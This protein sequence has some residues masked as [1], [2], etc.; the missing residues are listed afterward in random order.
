MKNKLHNIL[1]YLCIALSSTAAYGK[2]DSLSPYKHFFDFSGYINYKAFYD[3]RQV[4]GESD[5][6]TLFYPKAKICSPTG[7]I[8][9]KG[10][11]QMLPIETR[12]RVT[13]HGPNIH[14]NTREKGIIEV[15]FRGNTNGNNSVNLVN[16]RHAYGQLDWNKSTFIF[17]QTWHPLNVI[18]LIPNTVSFNSGRPFAVYT[19]SP[20]VNYTYHAPSLDIIVAATSQVD[21]DSDGPLGLSAQYMRDAVIPNLHFQLKGF[22]Q[23]HITTGIGI[24]YQRITP[25]LV[26][27]TGYKVKENLSSLSGIYYLKLQW[28]K[29]DIRNTL[30]FGGNVSNYGLIGGYA[31]EKRSINPITQS[32]KYTTTRTLSGWSDWTIIPT[33]FFETGW[34]IGAEKNYG[35]RK[36]IEHDIIGPDG[37]V[38]DRR[39]FG[40]GNDIDTVIRFSPRMRFNIKQI[41]FALEIEYTRAAFGD[42]RITPDGLNDYGRAIN[43]IPVANTQVLFSTFLFF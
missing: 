5:D 30:M 43:P 39:I 29:I 7:D 24:D 22:Y 35:S 21:F 32:Q 13:M 28:P 12:M 14:H 17:G 40:L 26:S 3:T 2:R 34:F 19:R 38:K 16:M 31:V 36:Q 27:N 15:E 18:E 10:Q 37:I 1:A 25:R 41:T 20:M 8:N 23:E 33:D 42:T 4:Q 11:G 9:A 6:Q